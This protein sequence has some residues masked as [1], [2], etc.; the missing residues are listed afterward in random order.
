LNSFQ[1]GTEIVDEDTKMEGKRQLL[2]HKKQMERAAQRGLQKA[3]IEKMKKGNFFSSMFS[4]KG[5]HTS[6]AD[7]ELRHIPEEITGWIEKKAPRQMKVR[8]GRGEE[9]SDKWKGG[10]R[11]LVICVCIKVQM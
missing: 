11:V 3:N 5:T 8:T 7:V 4:G 6:S 10:I 1:F 9:R 2:R